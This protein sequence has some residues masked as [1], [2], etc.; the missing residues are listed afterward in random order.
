V[1]GQLG[2]WSVVGVPSLYMRHG[3]GCSR[4]KLPCAFLHNSMQLSVNTARHGPLHDLNG[5]ISVIASC[6]F[7]SIALRNWGTSIIGG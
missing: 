2:V 1:A 3:F 6:G 4:L 5:T 7:S